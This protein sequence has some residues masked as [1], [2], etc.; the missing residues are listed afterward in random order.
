MA[1]RC[2]F[3]AVMEIAS[4]ICQ[5]E[6]AVTQGAPDESRESDEVHRKSF[7][8]L[9]DILIGITKKS[10][11]K[12][13][14]RRTTITQRALVNLILA[15][16]THMIPPWQHQIHYRDFVPD[17]LE[18]TEADRLSLVSNG[19]G[20]MNSPAKK[21]ANK[22]GEI[23]DKRRLLVGHLF[24]TPDLKYWHL[25]YF[26]QRDFAERGN[27]WKYGSHIHLINYLWPSLTAEGVW[28]QFRT[29]NPNMQ[30]ALHVKFRRRPHIPF[31]GPGD[32]AA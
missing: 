15:C 3:R 24:F 26:D 2:P 28:E 20:K 12:K 8:D 23:F 32:S 5:T 10:E 17:Q 6:S 14:C 27:H 18:L 25:F 16:E 22:I 29:G 11:L 1:M 13:H 31:V 21:A 9:M 30:G 19:V 7:A 4:I